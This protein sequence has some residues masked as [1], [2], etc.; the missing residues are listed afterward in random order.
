MKLHLKLQASLL[1]LFDEKNF[2]CHC[3]AHN[4]FFAGHHIRAGKLDQEH[5]RAKAGPDGK[6]CGRCRG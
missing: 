3:F 4:N 1:Y 2:P 6:T 5:G